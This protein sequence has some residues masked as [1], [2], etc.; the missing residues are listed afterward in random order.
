MKQRASLLMLAF[1]LGFGASHHA[2]DAFAFADNVT[3]ALKK[4][5]NDLCKSIDALKC[6]RK[7]AAKP[8]VQKPAAKPAKA[9]P[10]S[11]KIPDSE[12]A[13]IVPIP[14]AKPAALSPAVAMTTAS[15]GKAAVIEVPRPR[16][17]PRVPA[18]FAPR[19]EAGTTNAGAARGHTQ[20]T[21]VVPPSKPATTQE[22]SPP[23]STGGDCR[24]ALRAL[25]VTFVTPATTVSAGR[26]E[27]AEP[28]Q[29]I[30]WS[31]GGEAV[32]FPDAPILNCSFALKFSQW[33]K[34][35]GAPITRRSAR[36]ALAKLYTGPGFEC[37][38]RNGDGTAKISEHGFGNAV[39]ITFFKLADGRTVEVKDALNP[40]SPAYQTLAGFRS[41]G[42]KYFTTVLGPGTNAAHADHF[43]FDMG[44]HG[45]SGTFKI[46]E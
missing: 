8:G 33:L 16:L 6:K 15:N 19:P 46:C 23:A 39:D 2:S 41:T 37:R 1:V 12:T 24:N 40:M 30:L 35:E 31:H 42:C 26:C 11:E 5:E 20:V 7:A 10:S 13:K 18:A 22:A 32:S 34:A 21:V 36:S 38:G 25:G 3:Q 27:V 29:L 45:K 4:V 43:H 28:V 14:R 9:K 44:T 17:K